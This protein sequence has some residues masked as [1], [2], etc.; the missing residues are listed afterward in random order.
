MQ[1]VCAPSEAPRA[2]PPLRNARPLLAA[3]VRSGLGV[4]SPIS[5]IAWASRCQF[6]DPQQ[7]SAS[8]DVERGDDQTEI[9]PNCRALPR[10]DLRL[11]ERRN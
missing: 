1:R 7:H 6:A 8:R 10:I 5:K 11:R 9:W 3:R 2:L 4:T